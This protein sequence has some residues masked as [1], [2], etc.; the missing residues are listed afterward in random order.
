MAS[1]A[2]FDIG[3]SEAGSQEL[4]NDLDRNIIQALKQKLITGL[5]PIYA[6]LDEA[7]VGEDCEAY[8]RNIKKTVDNLCQELDS[9]KGAFAQEIEK[10]N[11]DMNEFHRTHIMDN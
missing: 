4:L 7:W 9:V 6:A 5:D 2:E 11:T 1:L 3:V 8:K 10:I